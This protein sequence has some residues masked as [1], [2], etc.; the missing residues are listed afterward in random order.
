MKKHG[1]KKILF[2]L[3]ERMG[4]GDKSKSY[5]LFNSCHLVKEAMV[6]YGYEV[7]IVTTTD[8]N[9]IDKEVFNHKPDYVFIE[10]LWCLSSKVLELINLPRYKKIQW[11]VRVHSKSEFMAHEGMAYSYL[12]EY[13]EIAKKHKNFKI[14][15]NSPQP[16]S[17]FKNSLSIKTEYAPN[18]YLFNKVKH[19][20]NHSDYLKIGVFGALRE[21]KAHINQA[22]GAL[23]FAEKNNFI[24]EFHINISTP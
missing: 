4:Y 3:K 13:A 14:T 15:F 5:G 9:S 12:L 1:R 17:D 20:M 19:K 23:E 16:I 2:I 24:I 10:A 11:F 7:D 22:L 21:F 18:I 6:K 8:S